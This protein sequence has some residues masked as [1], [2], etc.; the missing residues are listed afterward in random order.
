MKAFLLDTINRIKRFSHSLDV[1]TILCNKSWY[2]FNDEGIK[3]L[4]IF[5]ED[6]TIYVTNN[7]VVKTGTWKY[8]AANQSVIVTVG[9]ECLMLKPAFVDDNILALNLDGTQTYSFLID[10][11]NKNQFAPKTLS[12]LEGY[13]LAIEE[14]KMPLIKA[15]EERIRLETER[16]KAEEEER[17]RLEIEETKR[18]AQEEELKRIKLYIVSELS[19]LKQYETKLFWK[20]VFIVIMVVFVL[21]VFFNYWL[22]IGVA[23]LTLVICAIYIS[24]ISSR[25]ELNQ[26]KK[27]ISDNPELN[28]KII[29]NK[30]LKEW[31]EMRYNIY[32]WD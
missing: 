17:V 15:E 9:E 4:Y 21:L 23:L 6:G 16:K 14:A 25:Y 20:R 28:D 32:Y 29:S 12:E 27:W 10:E 1:K 11:N 31:V 26:I 2:V 5:Q 7:G 30:Q 13:F 18:K 19:N 22:A 8:I 3:T 24:V